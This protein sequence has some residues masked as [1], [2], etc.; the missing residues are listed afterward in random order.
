[1]QNSQVALFSVLCS[2]EEQDLEI[3][4]FLKELHA[5]DLA[6]QHERQPGKH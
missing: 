4:I 6:E 1:M 3:D 5:R 2:C